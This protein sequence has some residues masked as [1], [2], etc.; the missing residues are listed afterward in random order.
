VSNRWGTFSAVLLATIAL[1][2]GM[3]RGSGWAAEA[4]GS[5]VDGS[6]RRPNI[7]FLLADQ[8]RAKATGYAGDMNVKTPQLDRLARESICFRNAVSVCPVCTPYRAALMTGRYP[9]STGMFLNDAQLPLGELCVADVLQEAGYA[10]AYIGKWHLDGHGRSSYIPPERRHGW[11]YWKA[12]ECDHNYMHSHYY[13]GNSPEMRFWEGYDAVA[14]TKDAQAY[15]RAHAKKG[16]FV[17]FVSYG[18]PHFPHQT[19]PREFQELYPS[20]KIQLLPNVPDDFAAKARQEAQGYYAHCTALDR[21]VGDVMATLA[22]TGLAE[23]TILVFTSDHG[24]ML[25]SHGCPPHM[26]QVPWDEAAHV[27][28]LVRYPAALGR[29]GRVVE[30]PLSTPDIF[31]TLFG[32]VG[33]TVPK[34][35]EGTDLSALLRDM[36]AANDRAA[37]YMG[38]AP[39]AA[40]GYNKEYRAVRTSRY[41][42]VRGLEGPWLLFDDQRDPC[43]MENLASKPEFAALRG[44]LDGRLQAELKRIGD[45]FRPAAH[46]VETWGYQLAPHGSVSYAPGAK[47]QSPKQPVLYTELA[48]KEFRARIAN[49]PIAYLPLGTLEW[50]GEHLPLGTDGMHVTA[51]FERLARKQGGIVLPMLFLGPDLHETD[52]K[53]FDFYGMDAIGAKRAGE[54]AY[55][56]QQL[57]GSAYWVPDE[58]F[59]AILEATFKQLRRAGFRIVVAQGHGPSTGFVRKNAETWEKQFGLKVITLAGLPSDHAAANETSQILAI[60]PELVHLERIAGD[61]FPLGVGGQDPRVHA[62]VQRGREG[63]ENAVE[64]TGVVLEKLLLGAKMGN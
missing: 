26:K 27:P 19:A 34:S 55:P 20:A 40:K 8:W 64:K 62:S 3:T 60:R 51:V 47:V 9:T 33:I 54:L 21:C 45:D 24:E 13:E 30:T 41:T 38:V 57:T 48:P 22:E 52:E 59:R 18:V 28:L 46:Y 56:R 12:A 42:Y 15:L 17:L 7:V 43:Q 35:F 61:Q 25:G 58:T 32:L 37:L 2:T 16:P 4:S 10:T 23:N 31:P 1:A 36:P 5:S 63:I 53:G 39:F 44:D 50:H 29:Q 6:T 11:D 14:E 49:A